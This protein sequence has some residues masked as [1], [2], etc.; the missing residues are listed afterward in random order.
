MQSGE[1]AAARAWTVIRL[2]RFGSLRPGGEPGFSLHRAL[3]SIDPTLGS[4]E[5]AYRQ[6]FLRVD[7]DQTILGMLFL[8]VPLIV[9]A[10]ADYPFTGMTS[11]F[12]ALVAGRLGLFTFCMVTIARLRRTVDYQA[13]DRLL[14]TWIIGS[15][16]M[17]L[18]IN[19][20][21]PPSFTPPAAM[22]SLIVLAVYLVMPN[23][24][25]HR[26]LLAVFFSGITVVL[27][28]FGQ[29][30]TDPTTINLIIISVILSNAMGVIVATRLSTLRR[31]QFLSRVEL[32]RVRDELEI[33]ATTDS[34]TG[35]LNRR[36]F[37]ELAEDELERAHRYHRPL[38]IVAVDLDH[39]K[40]VNDRL[41]HAAGDDVLAAFARTLREQTRRQDIV[42][43]LG[44]E[45]FAVIVPE[46]SLAEATE[47]AERIRAHLSTTLVLT[48]GVALT[49]TASLG[50]TEVISTDQSAGSVL[51]R[52]DEALYRAKRHG[53][54]RVEAAVPEASLGA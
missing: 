52:A 31:R 47:L 25:W 40:E 42:G 15:G 16:I 24:L 30:G 49:V 20:V 35:A 22:Y 8:M 29:R 41:G 48:G 39:F 18:A 43:R 38:S 5:P 12:L 46:A 51:Q 50:V 10:I 21:R 44:G 9:L 28:V 27:L 23:Q 3:E 36:R 32:E 6:H 13:Y 53:R 17:L 54:N 33:M 4:L 37:L 7:A 1:R 26:L 45:E 11:I 34:L 14:A 19:L 2:P